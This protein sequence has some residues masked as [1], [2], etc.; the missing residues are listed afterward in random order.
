MSAVERHTAVDLSSHAPTHPGP[1]PLQY[2]CPVS[3]P[4]WAVCSHTHQLPLCHWC[5]K[6]T[7]TQ[8]AYVHWLYQSFKGKKCASV[9]F[10]SL[11]AHLA[12]CSWKYHT[13]IKGICGQS[14]LLACSFAVWLT[15]T[16]L[17]Y[18]VEMAWGVAFPILLQELLIP[19]S[20]PGIETGQC[21]WTVSG[22]LQ[23]PMSKIIFC[24]KDCHGIW[25]KIHADKLHSLLS[26][27]MTL[28]SQSFGLSCPQLS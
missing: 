11:F 12:N 25:F 8:S 9:H 2:L 18:N 23:F 22:H 20:L 1:K 19:T 24:Y 15:G 21:I 26:C 6:W 4:H 13:E 5:C 27:Q 3:E 17:S 16:G 28:Q 14:E 10:Q 7:E